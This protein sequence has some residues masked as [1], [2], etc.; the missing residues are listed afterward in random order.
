MASL[1][2]LFSLIAL[3]SWGVG[4]FLI[5]RSSRDVGVFKTL[6]FIGISGGIVLLPFAWPHLRALTTAD[7]ITLLGLIS[8]VMLFA[9]LFN[10]KALKTGKISV[11]EPV[12]GLELPITVLLGI[13]L[14]AERVSLLQ[15]LLILLVFAGTVAAVTHPE[16]HRAYHRRLLERGVI[17]AGVGAVAMGLGNFLVGIGSQRIDPLLTVWF[18]HASHGI[19][20]ALYL[21]F[22]GKLSSALADLK[23]EPHILLPM[24][25][26]DNTA[27]ATYA[28]AVT[29]IP[30]S[31]AMAVSEGYIVLAALLGI[32]FGKERLHRH[33]LAGA[34][35]AIGAILALSYLMT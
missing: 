34:I 4:D 31:I 2:I 19:I 6:L 24:A 15:A 18:L 21:G 25:L 1:G 7:G 22:S 27:W 29:F 32:Y 16:R 33:Q 9:A 20:A 12:M 13:T 26:L 3:F 35:L 23:H 5:Q 28:L 30:I 8:T 11:I 10:F 14:A 17:L